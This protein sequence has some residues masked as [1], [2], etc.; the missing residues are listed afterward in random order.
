ME[1]N[2]ENLNNMVEPLKAVVLTQQ[3]QD[4]FKNFEQ[5]YLDCYNDLKQNTIPYN[6]YIKKICGIFVDVVAHEENDNIIISIKSVFQECVLCNFKILNHFDLF[7]CVYVHIATLRYNKFY[8]MFEL[9]SMKP[10]VFENENLVVKCDNVEMEY[11]ECPV[12]LELTTSCIDNC[13]HNLCLQCETKMSNTLCP[14]C[15]QDYNE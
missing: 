8:N 5:I 12:C 4:H 1:I 3:Q 9:K 10:K 2:I 15:R 11:E 14:M 13:G 6:F 7:M